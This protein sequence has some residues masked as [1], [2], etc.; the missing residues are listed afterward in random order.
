[1]MKNEFLTQQYAPYANVWAVY[2]WK[3]FTDFYKYIVSWS[4]IGWTH[5]IWYFFF[6]CLSRVSLLTGLMLA[7]TLELDVESVSAADAGR[8]WR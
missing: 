5:K 8:L 1:M 4:V 2:F 3:A 6:L 7:I